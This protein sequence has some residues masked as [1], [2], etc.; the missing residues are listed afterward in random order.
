[1]SMSF[2]KRVYDSICNKGKLMLSEW[3]LDT[4]L[5]YHKHHIVPRHMNGTDN[6]S[7][8]T[9]LTIREHYLAHWLLWKINGNYKDLCA[10]YLLQNKDNKSAEVRKIWASI[11]G[12]A[13]GKKQTGSG[14]GM[15]HCHKSNPLLHKEWA[16]LGG[17]AH[18]G[19]KQMYKPGDRTFIRVPPNNVAKY[20]ELGFIFGTPLKSNKGKKFGPSK[21]RRAV[22]DGTKV[23]D[24]VHI[25]AK[26]HKITP[27]AV[28]YRIR[29]S[30]NHWAYVS[31]IES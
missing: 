30:H 13:S 14:K 23:Y 28:V 6:E 9:Y 17:K 19:K 20:L 24:S 12:K 1:M 29:S 4:N 15:L 10:S 22:T 8:Y 27:S 16:S 31:D 25:A 2:Y 3:S 18:R 21:R 26:E 7:N 5:K 11:G